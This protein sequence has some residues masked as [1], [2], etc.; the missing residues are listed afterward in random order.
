LEALD[1]DAPLIVARGETYVL[2]D[3]GLEGDQDALLRIAVETRTEVHRQQ[4]LAFTGRSDCTAIPGLFAG[5][6]RLQQLATPLTLQRY[7][8][9]FAHLTPFMALGR[10]SD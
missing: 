6:V 7:A 5:L 9:I 4:Y 10:P 1:I 2:G 3:A 8:A